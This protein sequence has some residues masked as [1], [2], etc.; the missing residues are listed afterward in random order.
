MRAVFF[1]LDGTLV[2]TLDDIASATQKALQ[3]VGVPSHSTEAIRSMIGGGA[4]RLIEKALPPDAREKLLPETL[5]AFMAHYTE[6]LLHKTRP[7]PGI[8]P[9]LQALQKR[10]VRL[11]VLSNKPH[12]LT[13][14]IVAALFP[15]VPWVEAWGYQASR[16][17]LK[18][19]P[20]SALA[21]ARAA[22]VA[23]SSCMFVG[24]TTTDIHTARAAQMIPV[25]VGWGFRTRD[26]LVEAGA[27]HVLDHPNDLLLHL[28]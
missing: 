25:G 11:G 22:N 28:G 19:D 12:E 26:V 2:D 17:A 21:L 6:G 24:D 3:Q 18:P 16:F 4:A 8:E 9:L 1:D 27:K 14:R 13:A 10:N 5:A 7:Y 15:E 20:A 23:P